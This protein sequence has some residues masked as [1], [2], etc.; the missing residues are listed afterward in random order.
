MED[1]DGSIGDIYITYKNA[2]LSNNLLIRKSSAVWVRVFREGLRRDSPQLGVDMLGGLVLP[3]VGEA[4]SITSQD[5][6][7]APSLNHRP[8]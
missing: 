1:R 3:M 7:Q 4:G 5:L 2:F 6:F 8:K